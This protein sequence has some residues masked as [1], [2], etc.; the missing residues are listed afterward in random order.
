MTAVHHPMRATPN[1]AIGQP[2]PAITPRRPLAAEARARA[3]APAMIPNQPATIPTRPPMI[4]TLTHRNPTRL[5]QPT[6]PAR[7]TVPRPP[8]AIAK[9]NRRT[10]HD[11]TTAT[12]H[13]ST[14][15]TSTPA[16]TPATKAIPM[17]RA[18]AV[19]TATIRQSMIHRSTAAPTTILA[20]HLPKTNPP[21]SHRTPAAKDR[22]NRA[23]APGFGLAVGS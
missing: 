18:V 21:T 5:T 14:V 3:K 2:Q 9:A 19:T 8:T 1:H 17:N 15:P 20:I 16:A 23:T 7:S 22:A 13:R 6:H 4:P 11:P 10:I 12:R